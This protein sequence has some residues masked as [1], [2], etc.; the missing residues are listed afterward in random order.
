VGGRGSTHVADLL[1]LAGPHNA[2]IVAVCDVW[3]KNLQTA[4]ARVKQKSGEE[5]RQFTRFA[6]LLALKEVDAVVVATPDFS[7]GPILTAALQAG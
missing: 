6:D 1:A 5:P 3:Q 2:R 7:H 4:A